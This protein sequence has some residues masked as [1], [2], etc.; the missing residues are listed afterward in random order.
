MA[1]VHVDGDHGRLGGIELEQL[2]HAA[3]ELGPIE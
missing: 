2:E 3:D 1:A